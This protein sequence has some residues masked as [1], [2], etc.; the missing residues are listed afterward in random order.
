VIEALAQ[1]AARYDSLPASLRSLV[2][3]FLEPSALAVPDAPQESFP[4]EYRRL[5]AG[6]SLTFRYVGPGINEC[7]FESIS[8]TWSCHGAI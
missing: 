6:Y 3:E 1:Y 4:L 8:S 5:D 2:P 7:R